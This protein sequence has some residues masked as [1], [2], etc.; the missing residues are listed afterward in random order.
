MLPTAEICPCV[1]RKKL[2]IEDSAVPN[3]TSSAISKNSSSTSAADRY[4]PTAARYAR[5]IPA[6]AKQMRNVESSAAI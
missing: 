6:A 1:D 5:Q 3:S 2:I 4:Q